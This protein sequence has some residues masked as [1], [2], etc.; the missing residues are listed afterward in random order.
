MPNVAEIIREHVTADVKCVDRLYL[1]GYVP[2]LQSSGGV[3]AFLR[4]AGGQLVPSPAIFG[5]ITTSFRERLRAW[6]D[7]R[8][9][10]WIEFAKG[11]RKEDIVERYRTRFPAASGVVLVGVAQER[12]SGWTARKTR[13]GR[14]VHFDFQRKSVCVNHDYLYVIDRG[15]KIAEG[16]PAEVQ[17]DPAVI[18]AYLGTPSTRNGATDAET[19][20]VSAAAGARKGTGNN[21]DGKRSSRSKSASGSKARKR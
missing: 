21:R 8:R 6:C 15:K 5:E 10:P 7:R 20:S 19:V 2:R 4:Q 3:V 14:H 17:R 16:V 18:A 11:E 9:I 1:N 12:A 13:T